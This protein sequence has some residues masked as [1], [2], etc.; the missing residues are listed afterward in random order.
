MIDAWDQICDILRRE[1]LL[2]RCRLNPGVTRADIEELE[3]H[4]GVALPAS[5]TAFLAQHNGQANE[6][7]VGVY[8]GC[9]L[10]S[11]QGIRSQWDTWRSIDEEAMNEDCAEFMSSEP[12]GAIKPMYTNR[13]WIPLTHDFGGNHVG[14]D[15]DPDIDGNEGQVITFGRDEDQKRLIADSF[16]DFIPI[17]ISEMRDGDWSFADEG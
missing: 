10:L 9:L 14:L 8:L 17:L 16:E 13:Q 6:A 2:E 1:K 15:F 4:L 12:K 5:L 11:T 3:A 7:A